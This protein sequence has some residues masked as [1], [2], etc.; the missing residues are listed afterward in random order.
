[1]SRWSKRCLNTRRI[2]AAGWTAV[3]LGLIL[4]PMPA[5][6]GIPLQINHQGVV[7][8]NGL[9]FNGDGQFCFALVDP[10]TGNNLWTNDGTHIGENNPP[11]AAVTIPVQ[12]G[13]YSVR[14]GDVLLPNMTAIGSTVFNDDN[15]VL[16]IWFDDGQ[17]N[18]MQLLSPDHPLSSTGYAY[19]AL[20]ADFAADADTVD[21]MHASELAL[22]SGVIVMW[23]GTIA[24]IPDGWALCDGTNGT[25]DLRDRFIVGARQ[26]DGGIAKT[27]VK[28][29]LMLTGGE[30]EHTLTITEMPAHTHTI[31]YSQD[32]VNFGP[33]GGF[34]HGGSTATGSAG[35]N[36]AHENCPPF[37]ALA[38][39]MKL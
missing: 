33:N 2:A 32:Q 20:S 16:R 24:T 26:D 25:P 18:G 38:F 7:S 4:W 10:D 31:P 19:S 12:M 15:V 5:W 37:Y 22:P 11:D 1:M 23:S 30:H 27:T 28:G 36:G 14:L 8:V 21:G 9:R 13:V 35:S 34:R 6:A 39:I 3:L 17:G 29:S